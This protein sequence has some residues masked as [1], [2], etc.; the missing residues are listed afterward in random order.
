MTP[1]E[2]LVNGIAVFPCLY[3][4]KKPALKWSKYEHTLPSADLVKTWSRIGY[5]SNFAAV[6]GWKNLTVVDF[7]AYASFVLWQSWAIGEGKLARE[8]ATNTYRVRSSRGMHL[9]VLVDD[10]PRSGIAY[11]PKTSPNDTPVKLCDI[12]GAGGY[13]LIP[14]SVHPSGVAYVSENDGA[15]MIRVPSLDR[16]L[17]EPPRVAQAPLPPLVHVAATAA[18][19]FPLSPVERIKA[20]LRIEDVVTVEK[21]KGRFLMALCPM[22]PDKTPSF[23]IDTVHQLGTCW[24]GCHGGKSMDVIALYAALNN[25]SSKAAVKELVNKL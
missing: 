24:S 11:W 6:C 2:I 23:R 10:R 1:L 4:T 9:Y 13:V 15:P 8:V 5:K 12:K 21:G 16:I 20:S 7:D 22:H 18:A 25:L 3:K 19:V 14:P 17:P